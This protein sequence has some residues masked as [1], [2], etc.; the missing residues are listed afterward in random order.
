[1]FQRSRLTPLQ[2]IIF[3]SIS[4]ALWVGA[5][6]LWTACTYD[7]GSCYLFDFRDWVAPN[8]VRHTEGRTLKTCTDSIFAQVLVPIGCYPIMAWFAI[9][10]MVM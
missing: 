8:D 4:V 2:L 10:A 9:V 6:I 3:S 5:L 1:M 7:S